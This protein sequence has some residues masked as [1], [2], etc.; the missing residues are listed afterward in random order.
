M[1]ALVVCFVLVNEVRFVQVL[2]NKY[3]KV[4]CFSWFVFPVL[5]AHIIKQ[6]RMRAKAQISR[7]TSLQGEISI[8]K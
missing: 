4:S 2:I 8:D 5:T 6:F 3:M 1:C 7:E